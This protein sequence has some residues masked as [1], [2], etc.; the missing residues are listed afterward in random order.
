MPRISVHMPAYNAEKTVHQAVSSVLRDLPRDAE[1]VVL[2]DGSTDATA[3]IVRTIT[4]PRVRMVTGKHE[5]VGRASQALLDCT[6]SEF[7]AR[8]DSD[9]IWFRGRSRRQLRAVESG[10]DAVFTSA[11]LWRE[12]RPPSTTAPTRIS[13]RAFPFHL[14][15]T[16]PVTHSAM[17]ARRSAIEAAG[18]YRP[19]RTTEDYDLYLRLAER[20]Y[21]LR[22]LAL[23]GVAYRVH[24]QQITASS[25]WRRDSWQ[26]PEIATVFSAL[27]DSLIGT[28]AQRITALAVDDTQDESS[29]RS[30]FSDFSRRF[31]EAIADQA[32]SERWVLTQKLKRRSAWFSAR[33]EERAGS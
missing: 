31:R 5:G 9:D 16:N 13:A 15:L 12:R 6:D 3:D 19:F 18:G 23:P 10:T 2:D 29:R 14:L 24:A 20:G 32:P 8:M 30:Q 28:P 7:V 4:D 22:R 33:L 27:A 11:V 21:A 26:N 1:V 25:G 17:F